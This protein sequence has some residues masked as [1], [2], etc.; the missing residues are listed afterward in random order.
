MDIII[1]LPHELICDI[2]SGVKT[3]ELRSKIPSRFNTYIDKVYVCEK[4][5]HRIPVYFS[6]GSFTKFSLDEDVDKRLALAASVPVEWVKDY[7]KGKKNVYAWLI[8]DVFPTPNPSY[9][10]HKMNVKKNPQSFNYVD[11]QYF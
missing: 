8:A 11:Y 10:W 6:I 1:T 7:R 4:G 2:L 5:K 9:L 3:I